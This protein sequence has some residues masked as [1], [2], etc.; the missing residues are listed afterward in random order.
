MQIAAYS[1]I[2]V[3]LQKQIDTGTTDYLY[4]SEC[5]R[6][7]LNDVCLFLCSFLSIALQSLLWMKVFVCAA[8]DFG[9]WTGT[10][11]QVTAGGTIW[12]LLLNAVNYFSAHVYVD[13]W[14]FFFNWIFMETLNRVVASLRKEVHTSFL[15]RNNNNSYILQCRSNVSKTG[16]CYT[17]NKEKDLWS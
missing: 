17:V 2:W 15:W 10:V 16:L 3:A 13:I 8:L 12:W 9:R 11:E 1:L 5:S 14:S 6:A 7:L 4:H